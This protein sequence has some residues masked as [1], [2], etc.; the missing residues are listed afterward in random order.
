MNV[1]SRWY[2]KD[3][4]FESEDTKKIRF[5]GD[6]GSL[7]LN[8]AHIESDTAGDSSEMEIQGKTIIIKK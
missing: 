4:V 3:V 2:N 1:I 5:T 7:R 6:I 8:R